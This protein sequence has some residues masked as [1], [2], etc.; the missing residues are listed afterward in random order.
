M[1]GIRKRILT[2]TLA[3]FGK[4]H[5]G[6]DKL[7]KR[8]LMTYIDLTRLADRPNNQLEAQIDKENKK[9]PA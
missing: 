6:E 9:E 8:P 4:L 1:L 2:E 5:F 3:R 7:L